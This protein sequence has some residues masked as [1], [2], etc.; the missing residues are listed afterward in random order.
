[1]R[2][3]PGDRV[4]IKSLDW[5]NKNKN[6][7]G[8]VDCGLQAF[9]EEMALCCSKVLTISRIASND[10][11]FMDGEGFW[12]NDDMIEGLVE[13]NTQIECCCDLGLKYD[14]LTIADNICSDK[15][16]IILQDYELSQE[17]DKWFAVKRKPKYPTTYEECCRIMGIEYLYIKKNENTYSASNYRNNLVCDFIYLLICRDAYWKIAGDW[18]PSWDKCT[19]EKYCIAGFLN[20]LWGESRAD[21]HYFANTESEYYNRILS[22]PTEEMR[23]AFYENFKE[24]INE[25]K[26]LL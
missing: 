11:Y 24:L 5:Y 17:G 3:K 13:E 7:Y 14:K 12:W 23:D 16:E 22:F 19:G 15:V 9:T 21:K 18:K 20:D 4:R 26:E 25:C 6:E 1:M 8:E 2:F 10:S